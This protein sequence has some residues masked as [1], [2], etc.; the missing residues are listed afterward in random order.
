MSHEIGRPVQRPSDDDG[1]LG[2]EMSSPGFRDLYPYLTEFLAKP[3][4]SG[5]N[6]TTGTLTL[7]LSAGC[8]KLCINDRPGNRSAFV[9][10]KT[11]HLALAAAEAGIGGNR[12]KWR[13]KGYIRAPDRQF[14]LDQA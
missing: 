2:P 14:C 5:Q 1:Q 9:S 6:S 7:F 12:I 10:G 13:T 8:F 11:L 4:G 3:R